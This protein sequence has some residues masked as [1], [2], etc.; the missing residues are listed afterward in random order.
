MA[1]SIRSAG[2]ADADDIRVL[3]LQLGYDIEADALRAR[4]S[5][6]LARADHHFLVAD[7]DRRAVAWLHAMISEYVDA[8]ACVVIGG[9]VVDSSYRRQGIG[10][11]LM[12]R[13]EQWAQ[14]Q[15]ITYV[16]LWSSVSRTDSHRFYEDMGYTNIKTQHAFITSLRSEAPPAFEQFIPR[17]NR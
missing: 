8:D 4:L 5:R 12:E 16:R 10:T 1:L 11:L 15:G 3:T 13:A 9:L 17:V 6:I 7:V 14:Q 2:I